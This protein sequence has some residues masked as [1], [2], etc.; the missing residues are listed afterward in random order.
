MNDG[1]G[2][3]EFVLALAEDGTCVIE[4]K[5]ADGMIECYITIMEEAG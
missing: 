4:I 5:H 1:A 2:P 3:G